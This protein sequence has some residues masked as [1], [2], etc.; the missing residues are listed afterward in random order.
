[1][2]LA[3]LFVCGVAN[4]ALSKALIESNHPILETLPAAFRQNGGRVSLA[5]EFAM[6]LVAMLLAAH[7]WPSVAWLYAGYT[8]ANGAFGWLVA[9]GRL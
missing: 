4:I 3:V 2:M 1:M 5:F 9:T 6:L 7:G 8:I